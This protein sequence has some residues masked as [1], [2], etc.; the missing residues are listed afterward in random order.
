MATRGRPKGNGH[1]PAWMFFRDMRVMNTYNILRS[2]GMK[3]ASAV[4]ETVLRLHEADPDMPLSETEVKRI[5]ALWQRSG[6]PVSLPTR[7]MSEAETQ[8][9][10]T[11]LTLLKIPCTGR[12]GIGLTLGI[13]PRPNYKRVNAKQE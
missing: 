8:Q 12:N 4:A 7:V 6:C 13:G 5:L 10:R 3:H 2:K 11:L 9:M 1:K